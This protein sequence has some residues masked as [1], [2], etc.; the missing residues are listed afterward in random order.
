MP[1]K[2]VQ[3]KILE[4]L[5]NGES[6][7]KLRLSGGNARLLVGHSLDHDLDCLRMFYPDHLLRYIYIR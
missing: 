1:L 7:G 6:I 2:E 5:Y 4:I 3:N